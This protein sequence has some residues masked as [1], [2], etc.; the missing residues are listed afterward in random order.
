MKL[1][2]LLSVVLFASTFAN[3]VVREDGAQVHILQPE[4]LSPNDEH[5]G[6][7]GRTF[8]ITI[9]HVNDVHAH[10]D[11]FKSSGANCTDM[12]HGCF[13]G[14]PSIKA[15]IDYLRPQKE[16]SLFLNIGDEFQ[17]L[18][19]SSI[20]SVW[21]DFLTRHSQG[22]LYFTYYGGEKIAQT[23]NQLGFDTFVLGNHE[24]DRGDD[25]LADFVRNKS[26]AASHHTSNPTR[27]RS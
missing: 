4:R 27:N 21:H 23:I 12:S 9:F 10:L 2:P 25:H 18:F 22:T 5:D 16:N 24:F 13:G 17:V 14:Y 26:F 20:Y 11:L 7:S 3:A 19:P 1:T 6:T 15:T 8:D